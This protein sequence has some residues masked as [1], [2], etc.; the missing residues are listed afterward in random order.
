M[1]TPSNTTHQRL[2][3]VAEELFSKRGYQSVRLRDIAT[4]IGIKHA[5]LYYYAPEGKEQLFVNVMT[6]SFHQ[7][8]AGMEAAIAD[9]GDDLRD[10][11]RAAALWLVSRPPM[12]I[13][14]MEQTDFTAIKPEN[15]RMLSQL[16]YDTLRQPIRNALVKAH[17][18]GTVDLPDLD[19]AAI[20]FIALIEI[21]H[22]N[23]AAGSGTVDEKTIIIDK[24]IDMLLQGWL[25]R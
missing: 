16:I 2:L 5:A 14:R 9:A 22:S 4:A 25:K 8:Q 12:N 20:T 6:R 17:T 24:L 15:A 19:M 7:H 11:M 10:Q 1:N 21:V 3:D 13:A 23:N 18:Q